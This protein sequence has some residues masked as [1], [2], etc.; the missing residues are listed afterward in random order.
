MF[1]TPFHGFCMS[2][3]DSVPGVS[4]GTIA[5]ILDFYDN[6]INA[7][8]DIVSKDGKKRKD[9]FFYLLKLGIGWAIGMCLCILLLSSLFEKHVYFLSSLFLGLT[10]VSIPFIVKSE[11]ECLK[12]N[13]FYLFF[14]FLGAALVVGLTLLRSLT[15]SLSVGNFESL[16]IWQYFYLFIV[17][18]VA[19]SAM[20]LPGIS[21]S[22]VLLI[23][24]VYVPVL[25]AVKQLLTFNLSVLPGVLCFGFGVI[26][27]IL[28]SVRFISAALKKFRSATVYFILGLMVGSLFAIVMGPTTL[29]P[30]QDAL[31][32]STFN[33]LGFALGIAILLG[34]ELLKRFIEKKRKKEQN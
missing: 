18:M 30:A 28:L 7:L 14:T 9:A 25:D 21:G 32:F 13:Y 3:A 24:G 5:F 31:S 23:A 22:T 11:K 17:G 33:W 8:H 29:S 19:I 26:V 20:V 15:G 1:L 27:G 34:L 4:G 16:Q 10:V 6:F 12:G 2:L